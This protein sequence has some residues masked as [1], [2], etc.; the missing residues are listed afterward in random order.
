MGVYVPTAGMWLDPDST[1]KKSIGERLSRQRA[2]MRK[3]MKSLVA[4]IEEGRP[5]AEIETVFL[6][7]S[8]PTITSVDDLRLVTSTTDVLVIDGGNTWYLWYHMKRVGLNL[9]IQQSRQLVYVGISAGAIVAGKDISTALWKGWDKPVDELS[10]DVKENLIGM[11]LA[12]D[13]SFFPHYSTEWQ[14]VVSARSLELDHTCV[15]LRDKIV[16]PIPPSNNGSSLE[17][18]N[19]LKSHE[20]K[21]DLSV[22]PALRSWIMA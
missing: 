2:S 16:K 14:S 12:L 1:S 3:R 18:D 11:N 4:T 5:G 9:L 21:N 13:R 20:S 17:L 10:V 15:L 6:D 22:S 8:D 19:E 7:V